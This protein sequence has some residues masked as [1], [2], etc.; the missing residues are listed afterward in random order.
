MW[1]DEYLDLMFSNDPK[2][3]N[4][5]E[6]ITLKFFNI[7]QSLYKYRRIDEYSLANLTND[8]AW[9]SRATGFNDPYDS[10]LTINNKEH[11]PI[12]KEGL[13]NIAREFNVPLEEIESLNT[14]DTLEHILYNYT[15]LKHNPE[16]LA[17]TVEKYI[18]GTDKEFEKYVKNISDVFQEKVFA[19]CFSEDP[20]SMLMW[21]HY[22]DNHK[23]MV[24]EYNF[25]NLDLDNQKQ[26]MTGL[27]PVYYTS[28]LLNLDNYRDVQGKISVHTLAAINKSVE[29]EYEK[30][31]RI[32]VH[33]ETDEIGF[34]LPIIKPSSIILGARV[35]EIHKNR[36]SLEAKKK[37]IPLKQIKLDKSS[38]HLEVVEF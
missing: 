33:N 38:Y 6:G 31:W 23:G 9:F 27:H 26:I 19:S 16:I 22:A 36:L 14:K 25:N 35:E 21:S 12:H 15:K 3:L 7:P 2:K 13:E 37:G 10:S 5:L 32:I 4:S 20:T 18:E 8:T 30:E 28:E 17:T 1:K 29:W 34:N 24:I 11:N